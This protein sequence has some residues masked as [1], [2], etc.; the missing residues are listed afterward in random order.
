MTDGPGSAGVPVLSITHF[1]ELVLEVA[2][3]A[4]ADVV[5]DPE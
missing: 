4:P 3:A 1:E 2:S 5:V